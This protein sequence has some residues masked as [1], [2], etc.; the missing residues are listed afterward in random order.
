MVSVGLW[1]WEGELL[2]VDEVFDFANSFAGL[3]A[4]VAK[5]N[6]TENGTDNKSYR[7][8]AADVWTS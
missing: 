8:A 1:A 5:M 7:S 4:Y 2:A 6:D 3:S